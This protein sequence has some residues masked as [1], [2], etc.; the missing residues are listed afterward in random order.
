MDTTRIAT[1]GNSTEADYDAVIAN[2]RPGDPAAAPALPL[3]GAAKMFW[4]IGA[5]R[6]GILSSRETVERDNQRAHDLA[7]AQAKAPPLA[8]SP[9]AAGASGKVKLSVYC[10]QTSE[11]EVDI[12]DAAGVTKCYDNYKKIY[13]LAPEPIKEATIEQLSIGAYFKKSGENPY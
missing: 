13:K 11:V 2:W 9:P 6:A 4:R 1:I 3:L 12:L 10:N 8:P 5:I 7:I